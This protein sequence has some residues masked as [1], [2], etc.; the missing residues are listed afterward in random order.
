MRLG[1]TRIVR[2]SQTE[3]VC[4]AL[5]FTNSKKSQ[6]NEESGTKVGQSYDSP[7]GS[8]YRW[9]LI[10]RNIRKL[11]PGWI[12]VPPGVKHVLA[13]TSSH[14]SCE[15]GSE[16]SPRFHCSVWLFTRRRRSLATILSL[17]VQVSEDG[18]SGIIGFTQT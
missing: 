11:S 16:H 10:S 1:V 5:Y 3:K 2:E 8:L 4:E 17:V 18:R 13:V 9:N 14:L 15:L 12:L 7:L 6:S